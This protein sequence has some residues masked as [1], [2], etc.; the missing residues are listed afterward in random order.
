M[1]GSREQEVRSKGRTN[2]FILLTPYFRFLSLKCEGFIHK[3][4]LLKV[5]P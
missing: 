4:V 3:P 2:Y 5:M 1:V